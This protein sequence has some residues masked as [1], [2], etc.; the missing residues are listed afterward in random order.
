MIAV[1]EKSTIPYSEDKLPGIVERLEK[2]IRGFSKMFTFPLKAEYLEELITKACKEENINYVWG[3]GNHQ[4]GKDIDFP[5]TTK[6][7]SVK[8]GKI[9]PVNKEIKISS[10]RTTS[11]STLKDKIT[12]VDNISSNFSNYFI[13]GRTENKKKRTYRIFYIDPH[14]TKLSSLNWSETSFGWEGK[15]NDGLY[16]KINKS[17]SHQLWIS[18]PFGNIANM[19]YITELASIVLPMK[20]LGQTHTW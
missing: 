10:H 16:A 18:F 13:L 4:P 7:W 17:M 9:M 8:A 2:Y 5:G 20:D 12:Y 14:H 19:N 1:I 3:G 6:A 11:H 15:R